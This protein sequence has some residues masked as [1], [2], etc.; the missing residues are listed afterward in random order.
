MW[1]QLGS[2]GPRIEARRPPGHSNV[3]WC[4]CSGGKV[5]YDR[6]E[7]QSW[8]W[9]W[10]LRREDNPSSLRQFPTPPPECPKSCISPP[11]RKHRPQQTLLDGY[12]PSSASAHPPRARRAQGVLRGHACR[13]RDGLR[14]LQH[15]DPQHASRMAEMLSKYTA[16]KV[17]EAADGMWA[18]PN[19]VLTNPPG[20]ALC[21]HGGRLALVRSSRQRHVEAVIDQ[22]LISLAED[23]GERA[24]GI[25]LSGSNA[26]DGPR[27]TPKRDHR[28]PGGGKGSGQ[29]RADVG[30]RLRHRRGS[31]H[32]GDAPAGS[33]RCRRQDSEPGALTREA[34]SGNAPPATVIALQREYYGGPRS[35]CG[36]LT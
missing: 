3:P 23:Q 15:L 18:E 20:Q 2:K 9:C 10:P 7:G 32:G 27:G 16:M 6:E 28:S 30:P 4:L 25:I 19:T 12:F 31:L 8:P 22:F 36:G 14:G 26:V 33:G 35:Y 17:V 13:Q 24:V 29:S 5:C 1:N 34:L 21:L 11:R